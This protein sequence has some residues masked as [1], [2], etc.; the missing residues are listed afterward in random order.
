MVREFGNQLGYGFDSLAEIYD[1]RHPQS[2]KLFNQD[3]WVLIE[4]IA[5][6]SDGSND[7]LIA[8]D[9]CSKSTNVNIDSSGIRSRF[10]AAIGN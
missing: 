5:L 9:L 1:F 7:V 2:L 4:P 10:T 8:G 3:I 6:A